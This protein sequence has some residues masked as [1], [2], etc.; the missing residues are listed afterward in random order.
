MEDLR[1]KI[2]QYIISGRYAKDQTIDKNI[3]S[4]PA[5]DQREY[6]ELVKI[7]ELSDHL[8][9]YKMADKEV[10]WQ[11]ITRE[12]GIEAAAVVPLWRRWQAAAAVLLLLVVALFALWPRDSYVTHMAAVD[13]EHLL[14]DNSKVRLTQGT[15]IRYLKAAKFLDAD[16][17]EV[18]LEGEATFEVEHDGTKPFAAR[19]EYTS[20]EVLGTVFRYRVDGE[21]SESEVISGQVRFIAN[22]GSSPVI[23][24]AGDKASHQVGDTIATERALVE[25]EEVAEETVEPAPSTAPAAKETLA[26]TNNIRISHLIRILKEQYP[27]ELELASSLS[28]HQNRAVVR[29]NMNLGLT[30]LLAELYASS[31]VEIQYARTDDNTFVLSSLLGQ[32][33]GLEPDYTYRDFKAGT[34]FKQVPD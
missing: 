11:N 22:D 32:D 15:E 14:P 3:L 7:F 23:L 16:R 8:G 27:D 30:E 13:E 5:F 24:E 18:F 12:A 33:M 28:N 2:L 9:D 17:R 29:V 21:F 4:D 34:P 19:S 6:D 10:A 25:L 20:V 1:D 31:A 26:P